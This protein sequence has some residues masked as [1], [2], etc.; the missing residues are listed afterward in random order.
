MNDVIER[1]ATRR[2]EA[3]LSGRSRWA[4][5]AIAAV[6]GVGALFGGYGLLSDAEGLGAKESWLDGSPFRDYKLPAIVLLVIIGGGMLVTA[7]AALRRSTS[8]AQAVL[9]MGLTLLAW[10][11]VETITIGYRG[12]G[13]LVMLGLFVVGPALLLIKIGS[14]AGGWSWFRRAMWR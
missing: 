8:A 9:A 5:V 1:E 12:S 3:G 11:G 7:A 13:Q 2:P 14:E 4:A 10:G 6:V